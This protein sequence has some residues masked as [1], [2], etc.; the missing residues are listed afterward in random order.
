MID[1]YSVDLNINFCC[2]FIESQNEA[3]TSSGFG[4]ATVSNFIKQRG[5]LTEDTWTFSSPGI[6]PF[7]LFPPNFTRI[8]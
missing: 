1:L 7:S 2:S 6:E 3:K 5:E 8:G 4:A